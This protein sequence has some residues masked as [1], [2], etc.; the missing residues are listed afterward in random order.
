[1]KH[2]NE[3]EK[4]VSAGTSYK[5]C[6]RGV[7]RRRTE[8]A[9]GVWMIQN[10]CGSAF[11]G[12]VRPVTPFLWQRCGGS[13]ACGGSPTFLSRRSSRQH[14]CL[15]V[16]SPRRTVDLLPPTGW[17]PCQCFIRPEHR[18]VRPRHVRDHLILVLNVAH[19]PPQAVRLRPCDPH[20]LTH[21]HRRHGINPAV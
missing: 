10:L 9:C 11:M 7:D 4:S 14:R 18:P 19:R 5:D 13:P 8:I 1:M 16:S 6:F 12:Y 15:T 20:C 2:T 17:R 21:D 3:F